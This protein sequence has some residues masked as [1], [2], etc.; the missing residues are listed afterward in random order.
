M[1]GD[2]KDVC[3]TE[4]RAAHVAAKA[5]AKRQPLT[6]AAPTTR[7]R[8]KSTTLSRVTRRTAVC[9]TRRFISAS[10]KPLQQVSAKK[11]DPIRVL[12]H[13]LRERD[14]RF[15]VR[16]SGLPLTH[17]MRYQPTVFVSRMIAVLARASTGFRAFEREGKSAGPLPPYRTRPPAYVRRRTD[18]ARIDCL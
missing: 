11:K 6:R 4:A 18:D 10:R 12:F 14:L 8:S 2:A 9:T 5:D 16:L 17:R 13:L 3:M 15:A 1:D 7:S